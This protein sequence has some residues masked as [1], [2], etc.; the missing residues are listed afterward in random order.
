MVAEIN[1]TSTSWC[2][3]SNDRSNRGS[4]LNKTNCENDYSIVNRKS[5]IIKPNCMICLEKMKNLKPFHIHLLLKN[6]E[7]INLMYNNQTYQV[8]FKTYDR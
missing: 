6:R 3:V 2:S 1:R 5:K 8:V 7:T 4:E